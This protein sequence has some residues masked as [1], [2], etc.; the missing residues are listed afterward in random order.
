[1]L[2]ATNILD[3]SITSS[4]PPF[5]TFQS[6]APSFYTYEQVRVVPEVEHLVRSLLLTSTSV[7]DLL[8][9][10]TLSPF[11]VTEQSV[12]ATA[13]EK[14]AKSTGWQLLPPESHSSKSSM[15]NS[16]SVW[17]SE[18]EVSSVKVLDTFL[19]VVTFSNVAEPLFAPVAVT[20]ILM[21]SPSDI[22]K[23]VKSAAQNQFHVLPPSRL[24]QKH[25]PAL[26]GY[27]SYH[28]S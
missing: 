19:P 8:L 23:P 20:D 14:A 18:P 9:R 3:S 16:A 25:L 1:M 11:A 4:N 24:G 7:M 10:A 13:G 15:M 2:S 21:S 26:S 5:A 6:F 27:H 17:Q 28:A 12:K 22:S